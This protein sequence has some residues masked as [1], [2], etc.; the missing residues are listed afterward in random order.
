MMKQRITLSRHGL[1]YTRATNVLQKQLQKETIY[2]NLSKSLKIAKFQ[3]LFCK[4]IDEVGI[5]SNHKSTCCGE[6]FIYFAHT[7]R[8]VSKIFLYQVF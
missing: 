1:P 2:E 7:A 6:V 8:H 4:W 3:I 5:V